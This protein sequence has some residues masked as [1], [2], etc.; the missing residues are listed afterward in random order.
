[1][2]VLTAVLPAALWTDENLFCLVVCR[3]ANLS[4]EQGNSDGSCFA[5]VCLGKLL[6]SCFGNYQA[7]FS[8]GKLGLTWWSS[9]GCVAEPAS[10]WSSGQRPSGRGPFVPASACCGAPD[11]ANR[12]ATSPRG[13]QP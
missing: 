3:M 2:D 1:M 12:R 10:S 9:A 6:G 8:F 4:L 11:V 13:L 5:Y 7:G